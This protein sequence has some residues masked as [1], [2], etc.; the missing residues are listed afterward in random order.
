MSPADSKK[1]RITEGSNNPFADLGFAD[2]ALELAK[3]RIVREIARF[4]Y[5]HDLSRANA[6]RIVGLPPRT[7]SQLLN[8]HWK[9]C[10]EDQLMRYLKNLRASR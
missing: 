3:S 10:S 8:G 1:V 7:F 6:G 2:P 5:D 9:N 4:V